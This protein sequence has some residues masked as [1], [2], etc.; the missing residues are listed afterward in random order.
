[1]LQLLRGTLTCRQIA[2][3]LYVSATTIKSHSRAIY[4]KLGVSSRYD[5]IQ[6]AHELGIF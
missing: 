4:R 6:R 3:E 1:M 2:Q 5:A